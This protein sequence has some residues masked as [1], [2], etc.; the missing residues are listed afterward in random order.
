MASDPE[1]IKSAIAALSA[2]RGSMSDEVVDAALKP[3]L[4]QLEAPA[5]AQSL[6]LVSIL[7][8][9]IVGSTSISQH[10]DPEDIHELMDGALERCT[11]TVVAYGG[12]VLQ[13]A[14][15]NLLAVFGSDSARED[16]S[17]RAVQAG[18]ALLK[19]GR[20]LGASVLQVHGHAG[21][22]VRVGIH[23]GS[24]LLG[25][26]VD[27][28]ATI[29]GN[30]VNVAARLEQ[31][32]PAG[33]VRI[34]RDTYR[35]VRQRFEVEAQPPLQVKG[36]D[37][38]IVSYL[39]RAARVLADPA[40][41]L[42][43]DA[44]PLVGREAELAKLLGLLDDVRATRSLRLVTVV[45]D[46]GVGK[47]RLMRELGRH[48]VDRHGEVRFFRGR[49]QTHGQ[50]PHS[51]ARDLLTKYC[52]IL[53]S[54]PSATARAKL[55]ARFGAPFGA[56]AGEQSAL[57]GQLIG[58]DFS[59]DPH[60]AG[61]LQDG[62]QIRSRAFH[63][64]AQFLRLQVAQAGLVVV[65]I[66]DLHWAD[67]ASLDLVEHV[68]QSCGDVPL[69]MVCSTRPSLL[70]RRPAWVEHSATRH[71]LIIEPLGTDEGGRLADALLGRLAPK[72]DPELHALLVRSAEGNPFHMEELL[73]ML[74]DAGIAEAMPEGWRVDHARLGRAGVPTTLTAVLQS[75]LDALPPGEQSAL[76]RSSIIGHV[77]WDRALEVIAPGHT[78]VLGALSNRALIVERSG[79]AFAST[80][81]YA[82]KHHLLHQVTYDTVLKVA[83]RE[84]H[85]RAA[86]WLVTVT[87]ERIGE[88]VGLI[89]HHFERAGDLVRAADY[90][91]RAA[92]AAYNAAAYP[93]AHTAVD[94]ALALLPANEQRHRCA[95]HLQRA[96]IHNIYG[97]RTE[98]ADDI[99]AA[100]MC[101]EQLDDDSLRVETGSRR[102]LHAVIVGR[103]AE[104]IAESLRVEAL[105]V[106]IGDQ[107][108]RTICL[109]HRAQALILQTEHAGATRCLETALALLDSGDDA[110]STRRMQTLN[111]LQHLS[112]M[113][114][115]FRTARAQLEAAID[116]ARVARNRRFE[117]GLLGNLGECEAELGQLDRA[118]ALS[119][120]ALRIAR[121]I[122]DRGSEPYSLLT[123]ASVALKQGAIAH[124]LELAVEG[125]TIARAVADKAVEAESVLV[126]GRCHAALGAFGEALAG[127]DAYDAWAANAG[128][129]PAARET[130]PERASLALSQGRLDEALAI[131]R[132]LRDWLEQREEPAR[133]ADANAWFVCHQ[134]LDAAGWPAAG[135]MLAKA[136]EMVTMQAA[137]LDESERGA[138]LHDLPLHRKIETAWTSAMGKS[139]A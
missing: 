111:R 125:G 107:R 115:D 67:D 48:V 45:A 100:A 78:D 11:A 8:L 132:D 57:V 101:A 26:G 4:A 24:V 40:V 63:A 127:F 109:L 53:D 9:D 102:T 116:M 27:G 137:R 21:F 29:R 84:L 72:P 25:G 85:R 17:E 121:D 79:S 133:A 7:F 98:Q 14:G 105:A 90:L 36:I 91:G 136:R 64:I 65:M 52:D 76:Q 130:T 34:S 126:Q 73:A 83:R 70:E 123:L 28:D 81:E 23:T 10:L 89:A 46:A 134:V 54:D 1:R 113:R 118:A 18:L 33:T 95:L 86:E 3:L 131:V 93:D 87:G 58:L 19:E 104:A 43:A 94:R 97:R 16:D 99:E 66:D 50:M 12:R 139:E 32:A 22:D 59:A 51:V 117:G 119:Q 13:Y 128:I 110:S 55:T 69:A 15:D 20:Q 31:T 56:R 39:V 106:L 38:P 47:S 71:G 74:L 44:A 108:Q 30:A 61:I 122:G 6:R 96:E 88:H 49:A 80:R 68:V 37:E 60:V 82:F 114:G 138:Y 112:R 5:P 35:Q 2:L 120:S 129:A 124:G 92:Q 41:G 77:F 75:R 103:Y 62:N 135:V 42:D